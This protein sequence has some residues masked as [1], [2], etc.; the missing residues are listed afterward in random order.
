MHGCR[1]RRSA[2]SEGGGCGEC[3]GLGGVSGRG[4]RSVAASSFYCQATGSGTLAALGFDAAF[5]CARLRADYERP[6][7]LGSDRQYG[8]LGHG[9]KW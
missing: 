3:N 6:G 9:R 7:K 5:V 4:A 8:R 1:S 2:S